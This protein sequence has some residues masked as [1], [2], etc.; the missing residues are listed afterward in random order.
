VPPSWR[1]L[2]SVPSFL[3]LTEG[4][5]LGSVPR[6]L[7]VFN[8]L[9]SCFLTRS[10]VAIAS[11]WCPWS[12]AAA[13]SSGRLTALD[14]SPPFCP[15]HVLW[16]TF[17]SF[18][19]PAWLRVTASA[20]FYLTCWVPLPFF[21]VLLPSFSGLF[22]LFF[23]ALFP[24]ALSADPPG[25]QNSSPPCPF[26]FQFSTRGPSS[27][28]P[29]FFP[30]AWCGGPRSR[31]RSLQARLLCARVSLS[32]AFFSPRPS[33]SPPPPTGSAT[34]TVVLSQLECPIFA[35]AFFPPPP[36]PSFG[37]LLFVVFSLFDVWD[38]VPVHEGPTT[39]KKTIRLTFVP[40]TF[41]GA[42]PCRFFENALPTGIRLVVA[43]LDLPGF[44][45][46]PVLAVPSGFP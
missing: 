31:S 6:C 20:C 9:H 23:S 12:S 37:T 43:W 44:F 46:V 30:L 38:L 29:S 32:P 22:V 40:P 11:F 36:S 19:G 17:P 34:T 4:A 3:I 35:L 16:C 42:F 24:G 2:L 7:A 26:F 45:E 15:P 5:P 13:I 21:W 28:F 27:F 25:N 39:K 10:R 18:R 8:W 41:F 33:A 1:G 14:A